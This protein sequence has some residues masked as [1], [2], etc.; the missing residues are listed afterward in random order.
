MQVCNSEDSKKCYAQKSF[1]ISSILVF[2]LVI[3]I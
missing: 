1:M 3:L 2:A